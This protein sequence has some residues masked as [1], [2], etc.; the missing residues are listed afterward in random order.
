MA[1][2]GIFRG[3]AEGDWRPLG[4]GRNRVGS[5]RA[6]SWEET[7]SRRDVGKQVGGHLKPLGRS[8]CQC[9]YEEGSQE[10]KKHKGYPGPVTEPQAQPSEAVAWSLPLGLSRS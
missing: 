1:G 4:S 3:P 10:G 6:R 9:S 7:P 2:L 5:V 8:Y